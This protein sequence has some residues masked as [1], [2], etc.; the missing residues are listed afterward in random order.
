MA[1][2]SIRGARIKNNLPEFLAAKDRQAAKVLLQAGIRVGSEAVGMIP[3]ETSNLVNSKFIDVEKIGTRW[4]CRIGFTAE[5]AEA[6][7]EAPGTLLGTG[8]KRQSGKGVYWGPSGEP[9]YLRKAGEAMAGEVAAIIRRGLSAKAGDIPG[10]NRKQ[11]KAT[12][13]G[14]RKGLGFGKP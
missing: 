6:V 13:R 8:T 2:S 3:R 9:E 11:R 7:H 4:R 5:Y 12:Q 1:T 10:K 14:A